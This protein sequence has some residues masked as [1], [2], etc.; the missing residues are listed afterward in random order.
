MLDRV[1]VYLVRHAEAVPEDHALRDED[2]WLTA[3]GR[4]AARGLAR[5]LREQQVEPDAVLS[6][7]LPRAMQTA[8]LLADGLDFLGVV[9]VSPLL[10]PG[11]H[12]RKA[13]EEL[14]AKG[15]SVL[16]VGHEPQMS[17]LAAFLLGQ[18]AFLPFRTAQACAIEDGAPT[19][20]ARADIMQTQALFVE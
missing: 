5:L 19:F 3:R 20:T 7:P 6:S 11:A 8:E 12:P 14:A 18:P 9:E 10:R 1:K 15:L 17:S 13:A 4:E 16:V 2:R